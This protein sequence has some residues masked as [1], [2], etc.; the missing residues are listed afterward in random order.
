MV[1][2]SIEV[3]PSWVFF[4]EAFSLR[5]SRGDKRSKLLREEKRFQLESNVSGGKSKGD[6]VF[7]SLVSGTHLIAFLV[8]GEEED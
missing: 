4:C 7:W 2:N 1:F 5:T 8:F 6:F 3:F